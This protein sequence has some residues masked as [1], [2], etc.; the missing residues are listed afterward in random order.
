MRPPRVL[1]AA[2]TLGFVAAPLA[3]QERSPVVGTWLIEKVEAEGQT[4]TQPGLVIFT[5][6]HYSMMFVEGA[7]PRARYAGETM[8]GAEMVAAFKTVIANSGRYE[9][10]GNQITIRAYVAKNPNYMGDWPDNAVHASF[11]IAGDTM[12]LE[13]EPYRLTMRNVEGKPEPR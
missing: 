5:S 7:A 13:W 12:H 3:A 9:V 1:A 11:H 2:L 4:W 8:T 6:T 10:S